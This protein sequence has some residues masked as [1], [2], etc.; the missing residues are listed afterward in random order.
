[1]NMKTVFAF[2]SLVMVWMS[3]ALVVV[4]AEAGKD[5]S[6]LEL[7]RQLNQAFIDVAEKVSPS[8][9][10]IQ[11]AQKPGYGDQEQEENPFY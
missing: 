6:A 9:V 1:M 7:A 11:V 4:A 2:L 10:V 3:G 8:V 5:S